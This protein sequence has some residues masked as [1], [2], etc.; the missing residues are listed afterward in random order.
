VY[1]EIRK[2]IQ[3]PTLEISLP[4][5]RS[6]ASTLRENQWQVTATIYPLDEHCIEILSL[7]PGNTCAENYGIAC[8]IGTTTIVA[9]L[10]DLR[11]GA[12]LGV[13]ASHNQQARYGED[14]ISRMIYAC[15]RGGLSPIHAAVIEPLNTLID[16]LVEK[17]GVEPSNVTAFTAAGNT[18]MTHLFLGLEPCT[19]R[20]EPYIPTAIRCRAESPYTPQRQGDLHARGKLLCGW[21][22]HCRRFGL[23]YK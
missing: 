10:V 1:R 19:I 18:T 8:D 2:K 20:L 5:L 9:Q 17:H 15:S 11:S 6:M 12:I 14:V 7:E 4:S 16:T 13:E 21:R 23:W 3:A 22:Y